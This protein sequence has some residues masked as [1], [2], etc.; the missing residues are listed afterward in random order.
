[1]LLFKAKTV[2]RSMGFGIG[3][4]QS[5]AQEQVRE[6]GSVGALG[7]EELW[8]RCSAGVAQ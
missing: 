6:L 4:I 5:Q 3:A 7:S 2:E 8:D 1:M